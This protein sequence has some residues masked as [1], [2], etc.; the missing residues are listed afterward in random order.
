MEKK[1]LKEAAKFVAQA[2]RTAN[3]TKISE[4]DY[5]ARANEFRVWLKQDCGKLFGDLLAEESR[6]LFSKFVG[7]WNAGKLPGMF[8]S[9]EGL[10]AD[11][12]AS[13]NPRKAWG[14][15]KNLTS[16]EQQMQAAIKTGIN[17]ETNKSFNK[18]GEVVAA[19]V[20]YGEGAN[21]PECAPC[22]Q[23][24]GAAELEQAREDEYER[25]KRDR[26]G[27][28]QHGAMVMEELAPKA[29]G[30]EA[31]LEKQKMKGAAIHA[32]AAEREDAKDGMGL[33]ESVTFGGGGADDYRY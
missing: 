8:Y 20:S 3:I 30:R 15:T 23:A 13:V 19:R 17:I 31:Q 12:I 14:F 5:F 16:Q 1:L 11:V 21:A 9:P 29:T 10:P 27:H 25:L 26:K 22:A 28:R 24:P 4:D 32:G 7:K 33:D 6:E 18:Q 2:E